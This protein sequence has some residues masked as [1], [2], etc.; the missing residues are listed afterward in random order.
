[1]LKYLAATALLALPMC[2]QSQVEVEGKALGLLTPG[3]AVE[4]QVELKNRG[5]EELILDGQ[6][7]PDWH[8]LRVTNLPLRIAPGGS[9]NAHVAGSVATA[10]GQRTL[11]IQLTS[12]ESTTDPARIAASALI[13]SIFDPAEPQLDLGVVPAGETRSVDLDFSSREIDTFT[14]R[15]PLDPQRLVAAE[16]L[17]SRKGI[18]VTNRKGLSWGIHQGELTVGTDSDVQPQLVVPF[19]FEIRGA[20]RPSQFEADLGWHRSGEH[21]VSVVFLEGPEDVD[22]RIGALRIEGD[23]VALSQQACP[24][25]AINCIALQFAVPESALKG[26]LRG[27]VGVPLRDHEQTLWIE[28]GAVVLAP[29]T[30]I[31][32]VSFAEQNGSEDTPPGIEQVLSSIT[33]SNNPIR[34]PEP[35]G[36][37][38]VLR[39]SVLNEGNVFGYLVYRSQTADGQQVRLNAE[40]VKPLS[41]ADSE[42][43]P[44]EYAWRDVTAD[45]A[46]SYWYQIVAITKQGLRQD[47]TGRAQMK[48]KRE[49]GS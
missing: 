43:R 40:P 47:L 15:D 7:A 17:P 21:P 6:S 24:R 3:K 19:R 10:V 42:S 33:H 16:I 31:R 48:A 32:D 39:W 45:P 20:V 49:Q 25:P 13:Y 26:R 46:A 14:L 2:A 36:S 1:M 9:A 37:G 22:L 34:S 41:V 11:A 18:R 44:V 5:Q 23:E 8:R 29:D 30:Q 38:P 28:Y 4:F 12:S 35:E 27:R